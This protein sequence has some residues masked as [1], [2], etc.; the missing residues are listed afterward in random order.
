MIIRNLNSDYYDKWKKDFEMYNRIINLTKLIEK[1]SIFL[2]GPRTTGKS[3]L[4]RRQFPDAYIFDLLD[5]TTYG[6]L[7]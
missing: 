3:T 4:I 2:L 7:L 6:R 5:S 1:S